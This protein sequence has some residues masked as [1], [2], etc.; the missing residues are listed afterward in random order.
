M[1][2][3][4]ERGVAAHRNYKDKSI[5][6]E[7]QNYPWLDDLLEMLEQG[8]SSQDFFESTKLELFQDQ[9]FLFHTKGTNNSFTHRGNANEF[10]FWFTQ[11]LE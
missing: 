3:L 2:D 11:M 5:E 6:N 7:R 1:N 4:A 10:R 9:V 8:E